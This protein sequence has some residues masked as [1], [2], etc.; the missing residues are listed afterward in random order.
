MR[1]I[2]LGGGMAG[3]AAAWALSDPAAG[4]EV[5]SVTVYQRGWRL[6]GK[7]ASSRGPH[8]R[9]EEH[10][11]HV[12]L[13]YYENAFRLLRQVYGE[14]DRPV[15]APGCPIGSW[16]D[17]FVPAGRVGVA[18][19]ADGRWSSW[20]A[21]F[22]GDADAPG[23]TPAGTGA[24]T[25]AQF[26]RRSVQLL[27]DLSSS[28]GHE[29][30]PAVP[31]VFL[32]GSVH[33]PGAGA[34]VED[35][36]RSLSG[37][38]DLARQ[39]ETA[40]LVAA[41]TA[42]EVLGR[43]AR[44]TEPLSSLVVEH[45]DRLRED[46]ADRIRRDQ[47]ARRL[48]QVAGL[49]LA[50]ARGA[51]SDGLLGGPDGFAAIDHLDFREWLAGHGA[52]PETLD[53]PLVRGMYD[54]VF[55]YEDGDPERPRFAAGLGLFLASKLFF[56]Y[57]GSIF[58]KMRAGMGEVVFAPLYQA[59]RARGVRF[60]FFS[61]VDRLHLSGDRR[62]LAAVSVARQAR[63]A[64]G[65]AAYDPLVV[66][67]GLPCFP[68]RPGREQ[69][70]AP[71]A[72]DLESHWGWRDGEEPMTLVA[73]ADFDAA[74][75]ATSLGMVPHV[76]RELLADSDRWRRMVDHVPTVATQAV[77]LWLRST[78]AELGAPHGNPTVSGLVHP[79]QTLAAMGHLV[80]R[81]AWPEGERPGTVAYL[82]STLAE[83]VATRP[84][85]A[86]A[87]VRGNALEF[88]ERRAGS[89]WPGAVDAA[90]RFRWDLLAGGGEA[91][92]P[93]R[94]DSQFWTASVDPSDRYVQSPP[95]SAAHRLRADESGYDNLFLAGDWVNCGLNAGC[96]EAAVLGGLEAANAVRGRPLLEGVSGAWYGLEPAGT[97]A[98]AQVADA[99]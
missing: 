24:P 85:E 64:E 2:I 62:S 96:I 20:V 66:V 74:V 25:V 71:V 11:L 13:G 10:G 5:E 68:A 59:L 58:W 31:G 86:A 33:R 94:L 42:A 19:E 93:E 61:R 4:S 1:V 88:L 90:G 6:G 7:G 27:L 57:R 77:Q 34:T 23:D 78:D 15:T 22:S 50:C 30:P 9:I 55:A 16:R 92:G 81:E 38:G 8:G 52:S 73:G 40:A 49:V 97:P 17:A 91:V 87:A 54:L 70:A 28:L 44:P 72:G 29:G 47:A 80:E 98:P 65:V 51:A 14:L 48:W 12:W 37:F 56:E 39:A 67:G 82:C 41:V 60:E 46:W 3:L 45:L 99:R 26:V 84:A 69:L 76:C 53:S 95:G 83:E 36:F 89:V 21:T 79:F 18:E 35:P 63:L 43:V 32:S 75:L